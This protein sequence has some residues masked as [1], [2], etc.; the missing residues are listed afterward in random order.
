LGQVRFVVGRRRGGKLGDVPQ[1]QFGGDRPDCR[2]VDT[3][4]DVGMADVVCAYGFAP[5]QLC[6][7]ERDNALRLFPRFE[8][9]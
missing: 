1:G 7:V 9:A 5:E 3:D 6:G 2:F 8:G 4:F